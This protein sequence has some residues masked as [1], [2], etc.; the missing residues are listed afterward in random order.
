V[1]FLLPNGSKGSAT[2]VHYPCE[3]DRRAPHHWTSKYGFEVVACWSWFWSRCWSCPSIPQAFRRLAT[4]VYN[5]EVVS[6]P[7]QQS[8][9]VVGLSISI[10]MTSQV[11]A[12]KVFRKLYYII[13][14]PAD[15]EIR[16]SSLVATRR[17]GLSTQCSP[18]R[19]LTWSRGMQSRPLKTSSTLRQCKERSIECK[20]A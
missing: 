9:L 6:K 7:T 20:M 1:Y 13:N 5:R 11:R 17:T 10:G 4:L 3:H 15:F 2:K 8:K 16:L 14:Q 19:M 18:R 12:S